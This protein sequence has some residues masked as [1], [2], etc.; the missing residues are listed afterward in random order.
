MIEAIDKNKDMRKGVCVVLNR[1][2]RKGLSKDVTFQPKPEG[3][4]GESVRCLGDEYTRRK[5]CSR[6]CS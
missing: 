5:G 3:V 6:V 4:E 2:E 1:M